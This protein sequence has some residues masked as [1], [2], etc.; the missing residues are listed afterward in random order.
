MIMKKMLKYA[1]VVLMVVAICI[2]FLIIKGMDDSI[3][4]KNVVQIALGVQLHRQ[5]FNNDPAKLHIMHFGK[6][7]YEEA[8]DLAYYGPFG[9]VVHTIGKDRDYM[10]DDPNRYLRCLA[11][12]VDNYNRFTLAQASYLALHGEDSERVRYVLKLDGPSYQI[13]RNHG[14]IDQVAAIK[15]GDDEV[16]KGLE[17]NISNMVNSTDLLI[18]HWNYIMSQT[19]KWVLLKND[20]ATNRPASLTPP[21]SP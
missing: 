1:I 3:L 10:E 7:P 19:N 14:Y 20:V 2:S 21:N 13:S 4:T 6:D 9:I 5:D 16:R 8:S 12:M 17:T 11:S 18:K 15:K